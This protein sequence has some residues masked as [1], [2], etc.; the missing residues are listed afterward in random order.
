MVVF[1]NFICVLLVVG[2]FIVFLIV[3]GVL[4]V[5]VVRE[6]FKFSV[7][8]KKIDICFMS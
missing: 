1:W 3:I 4:M 6:M 5:C 2:V 7:K 8:N